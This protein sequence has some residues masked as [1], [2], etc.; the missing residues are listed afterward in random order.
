MTMCPMQT[1]ETASL[2]LDYCD[3]KLPLELM[4]EMDRHLAVCG[5]CRDAVAGQKAVWAALEAWEPEPVAVDF[6]R[7]LYRR[8]DEEQSRPWWK[9]LLEFPGA[10]SWKPAMSLAAACLVLAGVALFR[11]PSGAD[12]PAQTDK[13]D[14]E[15][16]E[17][18][19]DD[20]DMLRQL[21]LNTQEESQ[22]KQ[23]L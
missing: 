19:L 22:S 21:G 23:T 4:E 9:R 20:M 11:L 10:I 7:R 6:D 2:L 3:R 16:V 12:L 15:Q 5:S 1:G 17:K 13:I 14:V 8:I 18:T